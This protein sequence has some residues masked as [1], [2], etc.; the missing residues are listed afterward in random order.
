MIWLLN[1]MCESSVDQQLTEEER[2]AAWENFK[3]DKERRNV[4]NAPMGRQS[5]FQR[6][7]A[8]TAAYTGPI[9][10]P[11]YSNQQELILGGFTNEQIVSIQQQLEPVV[12]T[13]RLQVKALGGGQYEW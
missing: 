8:H 1:V 12:Q 13:G 4:V 11:I 7:A 3:A 5:V 9:I 2:K 10:T 6:L